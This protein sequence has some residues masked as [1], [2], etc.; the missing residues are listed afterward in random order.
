MVIKRVDGASLQEGR[1]RGLH[2]DLC[3][4]CEPLCTACSLSATA[5]YFSTDGPRPWMDEPRWTPAP[6]RHRHVGAHQHEDGARGAYKRSRSSTVEG[7]RAI[8]PSVDL[9]RAG[10]FLAPGSPSQARRI[11]N[12]WRR[13]TTIVSLSRHQTASR[14]PSASS[15]SCNLDSAMQTCR[16]SGVTS[17]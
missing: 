9:Q 8:A 10:C 15:L 3:C 7:D 2:H 4:A 17:S 14:E 16:S 1:H 12:G 13:K 11:A 5:R 6:S